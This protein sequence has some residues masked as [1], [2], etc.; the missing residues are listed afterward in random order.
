MRDQLRRQ[1]GN[2]YRWRFCRA[3]GEDAGWFDLSDARIKAGGIAAGRLPGCDESHMQ[4]SHDGNFAT[5]LVVF[6]SHSAAAA[7]DPVLQAREC[8]LLV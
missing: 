4:S 1:I 2:E 3:D 8:Y 5:I 6:A 7:L